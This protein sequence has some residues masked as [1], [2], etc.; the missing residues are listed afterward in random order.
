MNRLLDIRSIFRLSIIALC[1]HVTLPGFA[2]EAAPQEN[3]QEAAETTPAAPQEAAPEERRAERSVAERISELRARIAENEKLLEENQQRIDDPE[4]EY[5]RAEEAFHA[6]DEE[7]N[8]KR[9]TIERLREE[10]KTQEADALQER[11][12]DI[13]NRRKLARDRF[14]LAIQER[15]ALQQQVTSLQQQIQRDREALERLLSP[16]ATQP[17]ASPPAT[18]PDSPP[19]P[20]ADTQAES[21]PAPTAPEAPTAPSAPTT[22]TEP[23][24]ETAPPSPPVRQEVAEA[25][26]RLQVA[27]AEV[28][29]AEAEVRSIEEQIAEIEHDIAQQ[30][31]LVET[32]RA[33][34]DNAR[35]TVQ[36]MTERVQRL[37]TEG[38]PQ[39]EISET[40]SQIADAR[41][42]QRQAEQEVTEQVNR[43][44]RRQT[45]LAE[46]QAERIEAMQEAERLRIDAEKAREQAERIQNPLSVDNILR[47]LVEKGPQVVGIV[48]G[49]LF[50][51]WLTRFL[52]NRIMAFIAKRCERGSAVERENRAKTLADVF[53]NTATI[54]IVVGGV[55]MSLEVLGVPIAP[56]LGGAAVVGLAIAFGAQNLIRD[57]FTG[58]MILL[59][60]QYGVNDVVKICGIGGLVERVTLRV[61]VLRDLEGVAHFIPNGQITTVSNMTHVWSRALFDI[62]VAYKEDVDQVMDVLMDLGRQIRKDPNFSWLIL[63]DP[64]MLGVDAF[65][66]SAII[67]KFFIKTRPLQQWTVKRELNRRIKKRFDELGIEI[68]FPHRTVFHRVEREEE[69]LSRL[70]GGPPSDV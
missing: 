25:Q 23:A 32:A 48:L 8:E 63:D 43:L 68:P 56:L 6:I 22:V 17:V 2:Q 28:A 38:A 7:Y 4:G 33:R 61:T 52:R 60:N 9:R 30:Q 57:Y 12:E 27:E 49:V 53:Q 29:V 65:G 1:L 3:A 66:D 21:P 37:S 16:P 24:T 18:V 19:A 10:E 67:I 36:A 31:T 20:P 13:Q 69:G 58:F 11:F 14:D 70:A 35:D 51:L 54:L 5:V 15:Q 39:A 47:F 34:R 44:N 26:E 50:L 46:L 55:L 42:R 62:G 41:R 45:R 40:W 64:Q 59:E